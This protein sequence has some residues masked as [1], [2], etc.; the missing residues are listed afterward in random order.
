MQK[1]GPLRRII[2]IL[3]SIV[4]LG[5]VVGSIFVFRGG[6]KPTSD[7]NQVMVI[8]TVK[9]GEVKMQPISD[10]IGAY[11][12]INYYK[13]VN[14]TSKLDEV[15][16]KL[17]YEIGDLVDAG[18]TMVVLKNDY[19][20]LSLEMAQQ[21][22]VKKNSSLTYSKAKYDNALMGVEKAIQSLAQLYIQ[23][24]QKKLEIDNLSRVMSNKT[25]LL[26][27]GGFT[28]EQFIDLENNFQQSKLQLDAIN[29]QIEAAEI[30]FRD[31]DIK[32]S[33]YSIPSSEQKKIEVLKLINTKTEKAELSMTEA[34]IKKTELELKSAKMTYNESLIKA[35]ISGM[36]A[37]KYI[38]IGEKTQKDQPLYTII[39]LDEVYIEV[40]IPETE[41]SQIKIGQSVEIKVDAYP[42]MTFTGKV[43]TIYPMIDLKTRTATVKCIVQNKKTAFNRYML[44]PGMFIRANIITTEKK[45]VLTI[46]VDAMAER[47]ENQVK[48]FLITP[49]QE[50]N[51]GVVVEKWIPYKTIMN[52]F[53]EIAEGLNEGELVAITG[54]DFLKTGMRIEISK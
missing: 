35:P 28:K 11:G 8:P 39:K 20:K 50:T 26:K 54:I 48:V 2:I 3:V 16:S 1:K 19:I 24:K 45:D 40:S 10:N 46:P 37:M 36:V 42:D 14:V 7:T 34:D 18:D 29:K 52:Q 13:K 4:L 51:I 21:E 43:E 23:K 47:E 30:G 12:S 38:E 44:L 49:T 22:L 33:G 25:E 15:V 41:L 27:V 31:L 32:N 9:V 6:F 17:N 5:I 53:I